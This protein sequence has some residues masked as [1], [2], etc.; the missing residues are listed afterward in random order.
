MNPMIIIWV[1]RAYHHAV[2][3]LPIVILPLFLKPIQE[4]VLNQV[5]YL[6]FEL[7]AAIRVYLVILWA[8]VRG[9]STKCLLGAYLENAKEK[10]MNCAK[11][12]DGFETVT[13]YPPF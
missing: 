10:A 6:S 7:Y 4:H 12:A 9:F 13:D 1:F 11:H 5:P 2:F 8:F 3:L